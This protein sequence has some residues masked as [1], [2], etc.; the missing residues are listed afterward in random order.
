MGEESLGYPGKMVPLGFSYVLNQ[1]V[2]HADIP[3]DPNDATL[4]HPDYYE[5]VC[6]AVMSVENI[7]PGAAVRGMTTVYNDDDGSVLQYVLVDPTGQGYAG[8]VYT[9][10][11]DVPDP[12]QAELDYV[13]SRV[14]M[15]YTGPWKSNGPIPEDAEISGG[16]GGSWSQGGWGV[17]DNV[18]KERHIY[19]YRTA[20]PGNS[21]FGSAFI[22]F[23]L[24]ATSAMYLQIQ[25][26]SLSTLSWVLPRPINNNQTLWYRKSSASGWTTKDVVSADDSVLAG[27]RWFIV[28]VGTIVIAVCTAGIGTAAVAGII[29]GVAAGAAIS[30]A[31]ATEALIAILTSAIGG[32]V[33]WGMKLVASGQTGKGDI[34]LWGA[35]ASMGAAVIPAIENGA[36]DALGTVISRIG[37]SSPAVLNDFL[38]SVGKDI[39]QV[40]SGVQSI[41]GTVDT[42][43]ATIGDIVKSA[44]SYAG[45][46]GSVLNV[47]GQTSLAS[48]ID[49]DYWGK[50]NKAMGAT[51]TAI[52]NQ[53]RRAGLDQLSDFENQ[54]PWYA[55]GYLKIGAAVRAIEVTQEENDTF[56]TQQSATA[57]SRFTNPSLLFRANVSPIV[58]S[59]KDMA[60]TLGAKTF[61]PML[62]VNMGPKKAPVAP[63]LGAAPTL[64]TIQKTLATIPASQQILIASPLVLG[65]LWLV[66]DQLQ[67]FVMNKVLGK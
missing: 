39:A 14:R 51:G 33:S 35:V 17:N 41:L 23:G 54:L 16:V 64:A 24:G 63:V 55:Q 32:L 43:A 8:A 30:T 2:L 65:V 25:G 40:E 61:A 47:L 42:T 19:C 9:N 15:F 18:T 66:K 1:A 26:Y 49:A 36:G 6:A 50:L 20:G 34:D 37:A 31:V 28:A 53:I 58:L 12:T 67:S 45:L 29:S 10:L 52:I 46:A 48:K 62:K 22:D 13:K 57:I 7:I 4:P 21:E 3:A 5:D 38:S 44:Q 11:A 27:Y 60:T 56:V 59:S